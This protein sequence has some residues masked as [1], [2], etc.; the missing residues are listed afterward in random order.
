VDIVTSACFRGAGGHRLA[1]FARR[2]W[3]AIVGIVIVVVRRMIWFA[4]E[5]GL[6]WRRVARAAHGMRG[7]AAITRRH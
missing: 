6:F 3:S 2:R 4:R 1:L 5:R 7:T